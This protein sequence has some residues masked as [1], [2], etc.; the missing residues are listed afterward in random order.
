MDAIQD[1]TW[2]GIII[3]TPSLKPLVLVL[4]G[5]NSNLAGLGSNVNNITDVCC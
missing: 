5:V 2:L 1:R 4:A 3:S